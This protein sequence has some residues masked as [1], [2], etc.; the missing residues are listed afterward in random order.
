MGLHH[1]VLN[2]NLL[3]KFKNVWHNRADISKIQSMIKWCVC[4]SSV[5]G[6]TRK[7][8]EA[9]AETLGADLLNVND[10]LGLGPCCENQE[11]MV[12]EYLAEESR[13]CIDG[14]GKCL[15]F[16]EECRL[17]EVASKLSKYDCVLVGYWLRRGAPDQ[18]TAIILPKI[19]GKKVALFQTHGAYE[20]SEHTMTAFA[21]AGAM[22]G[23]DNTILG[24][25]SCQ[26]AVNPALIKRR[27]EGK[28]PG[29]RG[30]DL[31]ACKKR[32]AAAANHPDK[33]D[34]ERMKK[35]AGKLQEFVG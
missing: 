14:N 3:T 2:Q 12:S 31:E 13:L 18:R 19:S 9:A 15:S 4:Y 23:S 33:D 10:L 1:C 22:L 16:T 35:F 8:A 11:G 28:V 26:S 21:R 20:G 32:W 24:T 17:G 6:N 5:T 7:L 29:H 25:F 27:L 34:L 30:E